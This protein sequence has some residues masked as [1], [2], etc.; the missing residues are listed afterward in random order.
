MSKLC[1]RI[2]STENVELKAKLL[3]GQLITLQYRLKCQDKSAIN[4]S[5]IIKLAA[6]YVN[7]SNYLCSLRILDI[8]APYSTFEC[9]DSDDDKLRIIDNLS[10]PFHKVMNSLFF[11]VP[12]HDL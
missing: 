11:F 12:F 1:T 10:S 4:F 3:Y 2:K 8:S 6:N 9:L 7:S 5:E